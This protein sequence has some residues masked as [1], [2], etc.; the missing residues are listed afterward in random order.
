MRLYY[1]RGH[2]HH[3]LLYSGLCYTAYEERPTLSMTLL[4]P[5]SK[6]RAGAE[7]EVLARQSCTDV[8]EDE[9]VPFKGF[10]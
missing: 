4:I 8:G 7:G 9:S 6:P 3:M 1:I 5:G 10:V 2:R